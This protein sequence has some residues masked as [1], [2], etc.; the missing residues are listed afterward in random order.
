MYK[1]SPT[2]AGI[3]PFLKNSTFFGCLPV[4]TLET[5]VRKGHSKRYAKGDVICWRGES[6]DSLMVVLSGRL[7][8]ANATVDGREIVLNFLGVGDLVGEIA[9]LDGLDRTANVIAL[10]DS[11]LFLLYRRDLLPA[12]S[13]HPEAMFEVVKVLCEKLRTATSIIEDNAQA[14]RTRVARGLLRLAQQHGIQSGDRIRIDLT[15][16]QTEL[17]N[18]LGLSRGNV[19]RELTQLKYSGLIEIDGAAIILRDERG[20]R[21]A[22]DC[23]SHSEK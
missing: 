13:A 18:Y 21:E 14:M 9:V 23:A 4:G 5:L 19:S 20:L 3:L 6:G 7:K 2:V 17:G 16:S 11:D 10:E 22:S 15:V 12:L 1:S 8:I